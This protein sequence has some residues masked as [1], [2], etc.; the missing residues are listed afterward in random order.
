MF[1]RIFLE[2]KYHGEISS[3]NLNSY[4]YMIADLIPG[5]QY[6]VTVQSF[7]GEKF[8]HPVE[9]PMVSCIVASD[10]SNTISVTPTAPPDPV[11]LKLASI[12]P[13][14][15]DVSWLFPQQYGDAV[16]SGFQLVKNGRLYGNIIPH[17]AVS[18][19]ITDA[20]L[21]DVL[22]LQMISLTNHPVGKYT[23]LHN[24]PNYI[25]EQP[26][27]E[28]LLNGPTLDPTQPPKRNSTIHPD[29]PACKIGPVLSIKY[30]HLVK[31]AVKIWT[32]KVTGYSAMLVYQTSK[33]NLFSKI[34]KDFILKY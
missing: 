14:G 16:V 33:K 24:H 15:I 21:G 25:M 22:N 13:E 12:S 9:G 2:G 23:A 17:D 19:K 5:K 30:T 11:R 8:T 28:E 26:Q 6:D 3:S 29:Y 1:F 7:C 18:F 34:F 31:P 20:E 10:L 4:S 32:E 27:R